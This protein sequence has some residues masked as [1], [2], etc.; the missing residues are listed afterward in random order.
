MATTLAT[1]T[2]PAHRNRLEHVHSAAMVGLKPVE[3][4]QTRERRRIGAA[5]RRAARRLNLSDKEVCALL[6]MDK[7]QWSRWC[8]GTENVV[9]S[10]IY[11]TRLH[12]VFAIEQAVD[13]GVCTVEQRIVFNEG[14][15]G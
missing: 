12:P 3:D 7:G 6:A 5:L 2:L 9:L 4:P 11:G 8:A 15:R 10:R 14:A 13:S 1:A